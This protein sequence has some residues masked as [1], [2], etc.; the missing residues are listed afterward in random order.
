MREVLASARAVADRSTTVLLVGETGTGKSTLARAIH[1]FSSRRSEPFVELNCAGLSPELTETELFGHERGAFTGAMER[2]PGLFEV[3]D[4]GSL[5][6][7]E[8]GEMQPSVQSKLLKV[9][10]ERRFRR[11]GGV[12]EIEVDVRLIVATHRDLEQDAASGRFRKDLLYRLNVFSIRVPPLR[13]RSEDVLPLGLSFLREF[14]GASERV[15]ALSHE[16]ESRLLAYSWPGNVRE[17]RN[18]CERASILCP[19]DS[20]FLP[21]HFPPFGPEPAAALAP[22][23]PAPTTTSLKDAE[24][25]LIEDALERNRGNVR[26]TA[27]ELGISRATLYRKA[28]RYGIS[29]DTRSEP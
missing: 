16:L 2:K 3:A 21:L 26:A 12:A 4:G 9:L 27:R 23:R 15:P 7:D 5:L 24:R 25:W 29:V 17:L 1:Q 19:P 22:T 11:L 10:E 18:V 28:R 20:E 8:I 13:E 6:L 14:R